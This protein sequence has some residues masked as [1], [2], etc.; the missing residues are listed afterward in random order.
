MKGL[1]TTREKLA[2][3]SAMLKDMPQLEFVVVVGEGGAVDTGLPV[4]EFEALCSLVPPGSSEEW[5]IGKDLAAILYTS[6][7]TGKPK[8]VML[9]HDQVMAGSSIVSTYLEI[10]EKDRILA[11]LPF[12]FDAGMNQLMTGWQQGATVI[13][14]NFVF[15]REVVKV[16]EKER[17]TG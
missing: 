1:I 16:L 4:Y 10:T 8:G 11:V 3:L 17:V 5:A 9:S 14:V 2:G 6:G 7:S 13:L 15:A 12:S